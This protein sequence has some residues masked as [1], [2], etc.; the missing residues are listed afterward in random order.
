MKNA[1]DMTMEEWRQT[2]AEITRVPSVAPKFDRM[3]RVVTIRNPNGWKP[4]RMKGK[5]SVTTK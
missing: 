2:L 1:V 5:F 4:A 3:G